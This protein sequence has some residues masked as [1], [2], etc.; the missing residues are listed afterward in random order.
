VGSW[1]RAYS[2]INVIN[3]QCKNSPLSENSFKLDQFTLDGKTLKFKEPFSFKVEMDG[4]LLKIEDKYLEIEV[5]AYTQ[6]E[7]LDELKEFIFC[8][9]CAYAKKDDDSLTKKAKNLKEKLLKNLT[10][11]DGE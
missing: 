1:N 3:W 7:L 5:Y 10:E 11:I 6:E 2:S 4:D 8:S 9:W